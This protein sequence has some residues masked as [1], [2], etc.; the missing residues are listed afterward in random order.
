M[1]RKKVLEEKLEK[2]T[3]ISKNSA[4]DFR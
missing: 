4:E 3:D 1:Q 2:E